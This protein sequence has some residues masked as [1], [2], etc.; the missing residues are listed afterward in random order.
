MGGGDGGWDPFEDTDPN[1]KTGGFSTSQYIK[2]PGHR[3]YYLEVGYIEFKDGSLDSY[4]NL[5]RTERTGKLFG[6]TIPKLYLDIILEKIDYF[7]KH[8]MLNKSVDERKQVKEDAEKHLFEWYTF[9][10][11]KSLSLK[12][13]I[14]G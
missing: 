8:S 2:I 7:T 5:S 14:F 13:L 1:P 9:E 4:A 11:V 3:K 12:T 6:N 10:N